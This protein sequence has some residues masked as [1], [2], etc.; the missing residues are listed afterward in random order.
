MNNYSLSIIGCGALARAV[1][2]RMSLLET[3]WTLQSV[4][5]RTEAKVKEFASEFQCRGY[6]DFST[7]LKDSGNYILEVA[8][9][10][11][12]NSYAI[13]AL[14][15][16]KNVISVSTGA[17]VNVDLKEK[18]KDIAQKNNARFYIPHGAIG[19]LDILQS[20]Q[21]QD[22]TCSVE[23]ETTKNPKSLKGAPGFTL[24]DDQLGK[25]SCVFSG[26]VEE[27]VRLFPKN[28]NV[29]AITALSSGRPD[30]TV[31]IVS[32]PEVVRNTHR[33]SL[34][35]S[36]MQVKMEFCSI[37]DKSNPKSSVT[38]AFSILSLLENLASPVVFY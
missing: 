28:I 1:A 20:S 37:P 36:H 2:S 27:A 18:L 26:S 6:T 17:L 33:I 10:E 7:F 13:S 9:A 19:G 16:G 30:V 12:V 35:G 31:R 24:T 4:L 25:K 23:I 38:T 8:S 15:N 5:G 29:A 14:Q 21:F 3:P 11:A 22:K 32:D 34:S